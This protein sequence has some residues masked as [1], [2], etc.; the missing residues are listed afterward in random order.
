M[1]FPGLILAL[2]IIAYAM[3][4]VLQSRR[5]YGGP[6]EVPEAPRVTGTTLLLCHRMSKRQSRAS[7]GAGW[8]TARAGLVQGHAGDIGY[9]SY[10]Q[11]LQVSRWNVIYILL[12][13]SRS[14]PVTAICSV[15][16]GL[17]V[18][19]LKLF[20]REARREDWDMIE[21]LDFTGEDAALRFV[22]GTAAASL[23]QDARA[24]TSRSQ[25]VPMTATRAF[26]RSTIAPDAVVTLFCLRAR[27]VLGRGRM[28]DYW[29][30]R[31][32]PFVQELEPIL[33]YAWY[34][35]LIARCA[36]GLTAPAAVLDNAPGAPWD[37]V[38]NIGYSHMRDVIR[39]LWDLR[40]QATNMRLVYDETRFIDLSRSSLMLGNVRLVM[41][42][43]ADTARPE[44]SRIA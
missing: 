27:P 10:A 30:D 11:V 28:L 16:H 38:A 25:A 24:H 37:G 12:R 33:G 35:Q 4:W 9:R 43:E 41:H 23:A 29:L 40:L 42:A 17:P 5:P 20:D 36:E 26:L 15:I 13:I 39:G 32:R 19:P 7:L 18:P 14:W 8:A 22:Q 6:A 3:S 1:T 2:L 44:D 21:L 34:D 31:H